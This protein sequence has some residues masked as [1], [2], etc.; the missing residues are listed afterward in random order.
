MIVGAATALGS[1]V[2]VVIGFVLSAIGYAYR[3]RVEER[4]LMTTLGD[5][6]RQYVAAT[7]RFIPLVI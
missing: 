5:Q 2:G 1:W 7:K 3:V 6:Y 4:A